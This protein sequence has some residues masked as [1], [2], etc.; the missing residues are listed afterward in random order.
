MQASK[1]QTFGFGDGAGQGS[2]ADLRH[3]ITAVEAYEEASYHPPLLLIRT[4]AVRPGCRRRR[5]LT[6]LQDNHYNHFQINHH[7]DTH[8]NESDL[9]TNNQVARKVSSSANEKAKQV[10]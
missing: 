5:S 3:A 8:V 4:P 1:N 9:N 7:R 10:Y 2:S 6:Y